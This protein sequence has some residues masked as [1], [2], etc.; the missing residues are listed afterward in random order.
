[1]TG[2]DAT[3]AFAATLVD[4]WARAGRDR[5]GRRARIA[6][7]A[8]RARARSRRPARACTWCSTSARPRSARWGSGSRAAGRPWCCAPRAPRPRTSI[9]RWSRRR[10]RAS[11]C[12]C[13]PPTG[14]PS[15]ATPARARRSTRRISTATRCAG[16]AIP[17]RRPTSP[18]AG[19]TWRAL[20]SRAVAEALGPPAGPVHLNLPF[21]EPLAAHRRAAGRRARPRRRPAVDR[22]RRRDA[23]APR[24]GRRRRARR[25]RARASAAGCWS[26]DGAPA[27]TPA[28][29]ARFAAAAGWPV[30]ADPL[31][32]LRAGPHAVS[33]YEALLRAPGFADAHRPDLVVRVGAPLTS[34]VATA[35]LD[36]SIAQVLVDPDGGWLDPHHAAGRALR[37][38]RRA[39]ARRG[40]RRARGRARRR[41]TRGSAGWLDAEQRARAAID[42]RARR[43]RA[44]RARASV[45][46][47]VAAALPDGATLVVAS[48]L[49]VRALEWCMAP[50]DGLRV[51][52]NRGANGIDGF[53]S[54]VIGVAQASAPAPTVGLCGDLCFLHDTNGLLGADRSRRRSSCST[55][56]A[57]G[58]SRTSRRPSCP[59][60]SSCSRRR[61]VS[62]SWRSPRAHGATAERVDDVGKLARRARFARRARRAGRARAGRA[63]RPRRERRAPPRAV[64]RGRRGR[65]RRHLSR[66][67]G[68]RARGASARAS[69][70]SRP[71]RRRLASRRR[72]RRRRAAGRALPSICGA[73][74]RDD[75]LAV[76]AGVDP[77]ARPGVEVARRR[78]EPRRSPRARSRAACPRPRASGAARARGRPPTCRGRGRRP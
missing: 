72:C 15:C 3:T 71:T 40:R 59:S 25:A 23:R 7:G 27:S 14:R 60:S 8:A 66:A 54:T 64:G 62:T 32:Q 51:L 18:G 61:T 56:T 36:P 16:S 11:R 48:S 1:M 74:Q 9:R 63:A 4:E 49:P 31:S 68:G 58:S 43:A 57:A 19:A 13:A 45:A 47:D 34:K 65:R 46:R 10:T 52:A 55:T 28:T 78:L 21:R 38:R 37:G 77:A 73:A 39:A 17:A 53:V 35:W 69:P 75:E 29:A 5:R 70:G 42:A 2:R 41:A 26:R 6:F 22:S 20:A 33:T 30:L 50:R 12:S 44:T 24:A 76:A 67:T